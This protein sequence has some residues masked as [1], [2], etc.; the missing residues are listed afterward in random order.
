VSHPELV[1]EL[2]PSDGT[3]LPYQ[4][5]LRRARVHGLGPKAVAAALGVLVGEGRAV[6][7][8]R[9]DYHF[10]WRLQAG[11]LPVVRRPQHPKIGAR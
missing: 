4:E 8:Q 9:G 10:A 2:L 1:L 7:E 3:K 6:S 5:L 11:E